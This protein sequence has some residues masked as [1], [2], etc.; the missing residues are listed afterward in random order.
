MDKDLGATRV[1]LF[2]NSKLMANLSDGLYQAKNDK[3]SA[4]LDVIKYLVGEFEFIGVT[5]KPRNDARYVDALAYLATKLEDDSPRKIFIDNLDNPSI[6]LIKSD[7]NSTFHSACVYFAHSYIQIVME[8]HVV[9]THKEENE[10]ASCTKNG[11]SN[12]AEVLDL[13]NIQPPLPDS[14]LEEVE[15][16]ELVSEP[17]HI[18][19]IPSS[20]KTTGKNLTWAS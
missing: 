8:W 16:T 20:M 17:M 12:H 4:Y 3:M 6:S 5:V 9:T 14:Q 19:L 13:S 11:I 1:Q 15:A 10:R 2:T 7:L 18:W